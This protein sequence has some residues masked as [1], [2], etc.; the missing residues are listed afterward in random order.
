MDL[1]RSSHETFRNKYGE[2]VKSSVICVTASFSE[3]KIAKLRIRFSAEHRH[4]ELCHVLSIQFASRTLNIQ[5][6]AFH[7]SHGIC[8]LQSHTV[9]SYGSSAVP[10]FEAL[11]WCSFSSF[12]FL[13]HFL[14]FL[15]SSISR[16]YNPA[17]S[18]YISTTD[19]SSSIK[20][21]FPFT[22]TP[23]KVGFLNLSSS[24]NSLN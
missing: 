23:L 21:Y 7:R 22:H 16:Q 11:T 12:L 4:V 19:H 5:K 20:C 17:S 1:S 2:S 6:S 8:L 9:L 14:M 18:N 24:G 10:V 15:F 13:A 3:L